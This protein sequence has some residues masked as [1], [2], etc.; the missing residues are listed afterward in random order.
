[1][2]DLDY[3]LKIAFS[4]TSKGDAG[5]ASVVISRLKTLDL[6]NEIPA[7][8]FLMLELIVAVRV[9]DRSRSEQLASEVFAAAVPHAQV[10]DLL[11]AIP[12]SSHQECQDFITSLTAEPKS[13]RRGRLGLNAPAAAP[14]P[15][16]AAAP[17]ATRTKRFSTPVLIIL[18]LSGLFLLGIVFLVI[19]FGG[20]AFFAV[21]TASGNVIQRTAQIEVNKLHRSVELFTIETAGGQLPRGFSLT[22]LAKGQSPFITDLSDFMDPWGRPYQVVIPGDYNLDFDVISYGKDG[23]PGGSGLAEDI[24]S[25][26]D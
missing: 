5:Q 20:I 7:V 12:E 16:Q 9:G 6:R 22:D 3:E 18:I 21:S 1:M 13:R 8:Q 2:A 4:A 23:L 10:R 14:P 19:V 17:V 15:V 25:N 24:V 26:Q 11:M